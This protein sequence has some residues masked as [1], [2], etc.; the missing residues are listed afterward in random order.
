MITTPIV[1]I[2]S[3]IADKILLDMLFVLS[4]YNN[5]LQISLQ[6]MLEKWIGL[7]EEFGVLLNTR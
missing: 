2:I 6:R 3:L 7:K 5:P 4:G 1:D